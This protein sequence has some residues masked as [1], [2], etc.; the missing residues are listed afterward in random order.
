LTLPPGVE[1]KAFGDRLPRAG[2]HPVEQA[3]RQLGV[4]ALLIEC[5]RWL[6]HVEVREHTQKRRTHIDAIAKF[7][8][9]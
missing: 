9:R 7:K 5:V 4:V 2:I 8:T 1:R 6:L 3:Q